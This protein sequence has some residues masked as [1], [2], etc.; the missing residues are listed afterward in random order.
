MIT[1]QSIDSARFLRDYWQQQPLFLPAQEHFDNPLTAEELAGLALEPGVEARLVR[2]QGSDWRLDDRPLQ[3]NS[4]QGDSPW[5]LLVQRV[6]HYVPAVTALRDWVSFLPGW[7]LDDIMVSFASDGGGVGPHYDNYD[8]FLVQGMGQRQWRLGQQ[9]GPDT[10]LR[11]NPDLRILECFDDSA[12]YLLNPGDILYVPPG[13]AHWGTAVGPGMTYSIGFRAP[14][15]SDMLSRRVDWLLPEL[16]DEQLYRDPQPLP[17]GRAGEISAASLNAARAQLRQLMEAAEDN[18]DWFGELVT[19]THEVAPPPGT[20]PLPERVS[21]AADSRLA[22]QQRG[23]ELSVYA[24][25][26]TLRFSID[27]ELLETLCSG[28]P[29]PVPEEGPQR[30]LL[31]SLWQTGCLLDD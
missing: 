23:D 26:E 7:R 29:L 1:G 10:R 27:P 2:Q 14:R 25:G 22:W 11:D 17:V 13:L 28:Q 15:L 4:F 31:Q 18:G 19:E 24:N 8:V 9:C 16:D 30:Q 20:E 3:D 6:D 12:E 5:T 21:L